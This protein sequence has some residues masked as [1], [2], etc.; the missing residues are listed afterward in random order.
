MK[1]TI[2]HHDYLMK[3]LADPMEAAAY[4]NAVAEDGEIKY[5]LKA[6][7]NVIEAQGGI[8][9]LAKKTKMSRT[10]LYKTLSPAGN[11]E[12]GTLDTILA[13]Y[14]IRIGFFP[15]HQSGHHR[16]SAHYTDAR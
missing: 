8:G 13:N 11:P 2:A 12:V 3:I 10:S 6:L 1:S 14:G 5:I 7:R 16:A 9:K 4:L 15:I